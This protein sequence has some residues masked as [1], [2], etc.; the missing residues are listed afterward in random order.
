MIDIHTHILPG[1]DDGASDWND[2][3]NMAKAAVEEGIATIVATPHHANG[4][5]DNPAADIRAHASRINDRLSDAG[6]PVS[7]V[8]GQEIRVHGDL[9][10]AW[11]RGE[12]LTL[13]GSDYVLIELPSSRVPKEAEELIH[14]LGILKLRPIIAHPERNAEISRNP[15]RLAELIEQ[16]AYAQMTTHSLLGGFGRQVRRTA[17]SLCESGLVHLV[18]SDAH[19]PE[20]RGF[21]MRE[22]YAAIRERM[23]EQWEGYYKRNARCVA[24]NRPFGSRPAASRQAQTVLRRVMSCFGKEPRR[25]E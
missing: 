9:V 15:G 24:E 1:L 20:R 12:L 22:A 10:E 3:L 7:I 6:V 8:P 19:H 4:R 18:A 2:T 25:P 23:G 16:G 21:R 17:W 13:A 5:Y 14:E 11:H